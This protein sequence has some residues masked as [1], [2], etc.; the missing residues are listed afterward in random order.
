MVG[1]LALPATMG[2]IFP[3]GNSAFFG[4]PRRMVHRIRSCVGGSEYAVSSGPAGSVF[5][6]RSV[7]THGG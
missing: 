5:G 3:L 2:L 7:G 6:E 1:A 4:V